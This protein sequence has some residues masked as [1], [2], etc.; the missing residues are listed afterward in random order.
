VVEKES[1][2]KLEYEKE[3]ISNIEN[4]IEDNLLF[5]GNQNYIGS[6]FCELNSSVIY[7]YLCEHAH[8]GNLSVTQIRQARDNNI[9]HKLMES[10]F[11]HLPIST[12]FMI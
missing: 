4:M 5:K 9:R 11:S 10:S 2:A 3:I 7:R 12:A 6:W 1:I 8:S